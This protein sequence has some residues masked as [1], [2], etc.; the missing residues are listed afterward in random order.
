MQKANF[1]QY[2][3]LNNGVIPEYIESTDWREN[4]AKEIKPF[5]Q[6]SIKS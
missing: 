3:F 1:I 6:K 2:P 5:L 4:P